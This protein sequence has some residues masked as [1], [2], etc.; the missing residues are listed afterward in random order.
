MYMMDIL[1]CPVNLAGLPAI[2]IPCGFDNNDLPIG[3]QIIGDF[4]DE[5]GI[6]NIGYKLEQELNLFRKIPPIKNG[7][8]KK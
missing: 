3:F 4:F 6:L 5:K 7:G 8:I 2:S 1:T